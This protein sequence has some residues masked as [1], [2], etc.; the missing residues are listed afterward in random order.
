[1]AW[2]QTEQQKQNAVMQ[3]ANLQN[4]SIIMKTNLAFSN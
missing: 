1:M 4:Y 2:Y 3:V